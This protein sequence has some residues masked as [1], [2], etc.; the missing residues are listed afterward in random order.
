V[1][2]VTAKWQSRGASEMAPESAR[3]HCKVAEKPLKR[4]ENP[5]TT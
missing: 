1:S 5:K 2:E 4:L 3:R